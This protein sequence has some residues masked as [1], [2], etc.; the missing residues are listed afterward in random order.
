MNRNGVRQKLEPCPAEIGITVRHR[1]EYASKRKPEPPQ[2][3]EP[4]ESDDFVSFDECN[5]ASIPLQLDM[6]DSFG[7]LLPPIDCK[8]M[9]ALSKMLDREEVIRRLASVEKALEPNYSHDQ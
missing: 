8:Q 5:E 4:P 2:V 7:G 9:G 1:P 3:P 6:A